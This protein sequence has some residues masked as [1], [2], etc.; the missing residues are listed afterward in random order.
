[1]KKVFFEIVRVKLLLA[2]LFLLAS[3]VA[4]QSFYA[5][6]A[7]PA[8]VNSGAAV[9]NGAIEFDLK[10]QYNK[11]YA[12]RFPRDKPLILVFGDRKGSSQIE[13]WVRPL[14]DYYRGGVDIYGVAELSAVPSLM[15][16]VVRQIFKSQVKYSVMLDWSGKV[17]KSYSYQSGKANVIVINRKGE[18]LFRQTG[19][20]TDA[21][22]NRIY[23]MITK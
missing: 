12:I 23:Q 18:I 8:F 16:G 13:S 21:G 19:G 22:L 10:D 20:A 7:K 11:S 6:S 14:Y 1:M 9:R 5:S 15:Q 2:S 4:A 3:S 17:A